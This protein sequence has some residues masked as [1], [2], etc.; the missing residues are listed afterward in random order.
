MSWLLSRLPFTPPRSR[1][2]SGLEV[3]I[4]EK[5]TE[6]S[7]PWQLSIPTNGYFRYPRAVE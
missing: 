7:E 5:I 3:I 1:D 4:N 6:Y 2:P